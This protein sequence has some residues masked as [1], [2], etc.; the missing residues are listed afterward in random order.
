MED[1]AVHRQRLH[2]HLEIVSTLERV[3]AEGLVCVLEKWA[4]FLK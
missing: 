4:Q 1:Q 2:P 3:F